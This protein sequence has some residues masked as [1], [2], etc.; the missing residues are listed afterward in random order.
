[1]IMEHVIASVF[2]GIT[3]FTVGVVILVIWKRRKS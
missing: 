3:V 1:M 2:I